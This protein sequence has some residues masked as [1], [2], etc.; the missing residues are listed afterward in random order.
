MLPFSVLSSDVMPIK[1]RPPRPAK[2]FRFNELPALRS[3]FQPCTVPAIA[4][5][6]LALWLLSINTSASS[7]AQCLATLCAAF[8]NPI[9]V[10]PPNSAITAAIDCNGDGVIAFDCDEAEA[11]FAAAICCVQPSRFARASTVPSGTCI[12]RAISLRPMPAAY[13]VLICC[14]TSFEIKRRILSCYHNFAPRHTPATI[15]IEV[16]TN[17]TYDTGSRSVPSVDEFVRKKYPRAREAT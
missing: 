5:Q 8:A 1:T 2:T 9:F 6:C 16:I 4:L 13:P 3:L 15:H 14:Q 17:T 10:F 11:C 12:L 7:A